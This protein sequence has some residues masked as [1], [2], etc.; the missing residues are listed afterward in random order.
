MLRSANI[1]DISKEKRSL[2]D[3]WERVSKVVG[4]MLCTCVIR[5]IK[6][7]TFQTVPQNNQFRQIN[8][9]FFPALL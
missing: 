4:E 7:P 9:M 3:G 6:E 8:F 1:K 5:E 2:R